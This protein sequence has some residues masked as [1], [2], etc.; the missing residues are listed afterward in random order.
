MKYLDA[1]VVPFHDPDYWK[2]KPLA[3]KTYK[4]YLTGA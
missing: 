4:F 3:P 1:E 2:N